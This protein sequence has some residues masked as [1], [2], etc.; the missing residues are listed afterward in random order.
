M[1]PLVCKQQDHRV[2]L[3]IGRLDMKKNKLLGNTLLLIAAVIWGTAFVFQRTGMEDIGPFA[4]CAAR[5]TLSALVVGPIALWQ[6]RN[7]QFP[8]PEEKKSHIRHTLI[9]GVCCGILLT[10]AGNLQQIGMVYSTAGKGGFLSAMY[11]LP[12]PFLNLLLFRK[13][14]QWTVWISV[15]MA[16]VGLY[17]LCLSGDFRPEQGDAILCISALLFSF[18]ILCCDFFAPKGDPIGITATQ[19]A[20]VSVISWPLSFVFEEPTGTGLWGAGISILYCGLMSG[21]VGYTFQMIAQRHT[22]P[23]PA[24]LLMSMESVFAVIAGAI[25]LHERMSGRELLGCLVIFAAVILVQA[26][27]PVKKP[28]ETAEQNI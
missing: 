23:A 1:E 25:L 21:G 5:T 4:F 16:V 6:I 24:S 7:A 27:I 18:H 26:P 13:R 15:A 11:M 20:T 9:G 17:L 10:L 22:D 3:R 12:I 14:V 8:R 19:F 2:F 28:K